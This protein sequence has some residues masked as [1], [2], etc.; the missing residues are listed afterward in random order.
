MLASPP[1][2][3]WTAK[4]APRL[5][6]RLLRVHATVRARDTTVAVRRGPDARGHWREWHFWKAMGECSAKGAQAS[7]SR[8]FSTPNDIEHADSAPTLALVMTLDAL[9]ALLTIAAK[10]PYPVAHRLM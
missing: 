9:A 7:M 4:V 3:Q 5:K 2:G 10:T 1:N 8:N 6:A